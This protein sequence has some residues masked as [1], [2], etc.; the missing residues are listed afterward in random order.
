MR[1]MSTR[2]ASGVSDRLGLIALL[3]VLVLAMAQ[4]GGTA[5]A[6]ATKP[7]IRKQAP[8]VNSL[9][10][11]RQF[12]PAAVGTTLRSYSFSLPGRGVASISFTGSLVCSNSGANDSRVVDFAT[13]ITTGINQP[14]DLT[15]SGALRHAAVLRSNTSDT[16]NLATT[17]VITYASGGSKSVHFRLDRLRQDAETSCIVYDA[18]FTVVYVPT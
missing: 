11:C 5:T 2:L 3:G 1:S 16:F 18:A 14:A 17:R 10:Y 4:L 9:G 6:G 15:G 13:Q 12:V 7:V 8:C